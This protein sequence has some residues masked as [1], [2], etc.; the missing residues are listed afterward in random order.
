MDVGINIIVSLI[1]G[2]RS[3]HVKQSLL[4]IEVGFVVVMSTL[5]RATSLFSFKVCK[6]SRAPLGPIRRFDHS[7]QYNLYKL[8]YLY[9]LI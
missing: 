6:T 3:I 1:W 2:S 4:T 8:I 5:E 7:S 9:N